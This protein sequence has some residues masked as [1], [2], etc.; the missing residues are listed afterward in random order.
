MSEQATKGYQ[1][2]ESQV[3]TEGYQPQGS[4]EIPLVVPDL[5][6]GVMPPTSSPSV[7]SSAPQSETGE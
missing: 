4:S 3:L 7:P 2:S 5:V 6:S 1:P